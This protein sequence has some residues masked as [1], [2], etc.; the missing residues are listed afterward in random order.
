MSPRNV[1]VLVARS[2]AIKIVGVNYLDFLN[3]IEY[4][5]WNASQESEL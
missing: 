2:A 5:W 3:F 4:L 1:H